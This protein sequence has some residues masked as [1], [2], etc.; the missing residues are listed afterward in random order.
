[1]RW[2]MCVKVFLEVATL[3][4]SLP[5]TVAPDG[6]V[7]VFPTTTVVDFFPKVRHRVAHH[8][9][10]MLCRRAHIRQRWRCMHNRWRAHHRRGA[11]LLRIWLT[12]PLV[13]QRVD[14][15]DNELVDIVAPLLGR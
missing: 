11:G 2:C 1:M 12:S 3:D 9:C 14:D 13:V 5:L 15:S 7:A 6:G 8:W 4:I 10:A